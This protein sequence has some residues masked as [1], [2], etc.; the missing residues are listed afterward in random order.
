MYN[1][2]S[3][4]LINTSELSQLQLVWVKDPEFPYL[5]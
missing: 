4:H 3:T 5:C 2:D 1:N